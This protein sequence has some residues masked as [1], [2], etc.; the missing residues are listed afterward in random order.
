MILKKDAEHFNIHKLFQHLTVDFE[1]WMEKTDDQKSDAWKGV[2]TFVSGFFN[3]F[4]H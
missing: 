2:W 1:D 4:P 3:L